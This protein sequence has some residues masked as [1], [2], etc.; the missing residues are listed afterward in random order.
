MIL[1]IFV[2]VC[3]RVSDAPAAE[4]T[5][6]ENF[7]LT[8]VKIVGIKSVSKKDLEKTLAAR[9]PVRWKIWIPKPVLSKSDLDED[10]TR[11]KQFYQRNG[12]YHTEAVHS[13]NISKPAGS[14][15]DSGKDESKEG[16]LADVAVTYTVTEGPPVRVEAIDI[17]VEKPVDGI[18]ESRLGSSLPIQT[19][20]IFVIDA[21]NA[22][23]K[24]LSR[25]YGNNGYAR[26]ETSGKVIVDPEVN[27]A[28]ITFRI[29]P[30]IRYFF[31]DIEIKDND[32]YVKDIVIHRAIRF[33]PGELYSS[34][35]IEQSQR[36][37]FNLDAFKVSLVNTGKPEPG[38]DTLPIEVKVKPKKR[39]S[40]KAG[41]GYGNEDGLRL[42]GGWAYRNLSGWG[43]KFSVDAKRSDLIDLARGSYVQPYFMGERHTLNTNA[44]FQQDKLDSYTSRSIFANAFLER[45]LSA[46]WRG[47]VGYNFDL[48]EITELKI[49]DPLGIAD[50]QEGKNYLISAPQIGFF[51][52]TT[53][54]DAD[55]TLG[56]SFSLSGQLATSLLGSELTFFQPYVEYKTYHALRPRWVLAGRIRYDTIQE[57]EDTD[58]IPINKRLFL[59]GTNTVRGY[60][61]QK[62]GPL[63]AAGNPVGG[64]SAVNGNVEL[65]YPIYKKI[66]GVVFVDM[67]FVGADPFTLNNDELR[68]TSGAGLRYNTP[69]GPL[70][71]DFGYKLNPPTLGDVAVTPVPNPDDDIEDRWK[72]HFSIGQA[73]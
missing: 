53:D 31:G 37:L 72:I 14:D 27:T 33:K 48:S 36:N 15:T 16:A 42:S 52:D 20:N 23:K 19:G 18:E 25:M 57:T 26:V 11:I 5:V 70:R 63:D 73:F 2:L 43:G 54:N 58:F 64:Q 1:F 10:L 38:S 44:G 22:A 21:Y 6:P 17:R 71:L 9:L 35:K 61:Y 60:S 46:D 4:M 66:S 3:F 29:D 34:K 55:P 49:T 69:I 68:F 8:G 50:I 47:K 24:E 51:R 41:I 39:N 56:S 65:R 67:G 7:R 12:Y 30:G 40:V 59:G 62:L 45:K 28:R 13:V 32:G